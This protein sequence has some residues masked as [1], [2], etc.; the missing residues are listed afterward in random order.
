MR[1]RA[2]LGTIILAFAAAAISLG[3]VAIRAVRYGI[4]EA[5]PLLGG[6][7]MLALAVAGYARLKN[8][9]RS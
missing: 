7:L 2:Q 9:P 1:T 5:T 4:V 6:L 3:T 8:S